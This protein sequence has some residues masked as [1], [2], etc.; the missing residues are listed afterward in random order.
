M[1]LVSL[2]L[3]VVGQF[4]MSMTSMITGPSMAVQRPEVK[5]E[6]KLT[7]DQN[8][9]IDT[10]VNDLNKVMRDRATANNPSAFMTAIKDSNEKV[11]QIL[12]DPQDARLRELIL[13]MKGPTALLE[14]ETAKALGLSEE[15][16]AKLKEIKSQASKESMTAMQGGIEGQKKLKGILDK[17]DTDAVAVL[18][19]DQKKKYTE[20]QGKLVKNLRMQMPIFG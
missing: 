6:L 5:K 19:E 2:L 20:M 17:F 15:Q 7:K 10:V 11:W 3:L 12:D 18:T 8:K 16:S 9:Q 14:E 4:G 13:Q 1:K